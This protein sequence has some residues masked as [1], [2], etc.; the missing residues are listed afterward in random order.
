MLFANFAHLIAAQYS[1][2]ISISSQTAGS[3]KAYLPPTILYSYCSGCCGD[4]EAGLSPALA[5]GAAVLNKIRLIQ[6]SFPDTIP[7]VYQSTR[8]QG[9]TA[10]V[11]NTHLEVEVLGFSTD[12]SGACRL[13]P[14]SPTMLRGGVSLPTVLPHVCSHIPMSEPSQ[15]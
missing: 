7:V 15:A 13:A 2:A 14:Y 4:C 3:S 5:G 12:P 8:G 10:G 6:H 11:Q 9:H 1:S